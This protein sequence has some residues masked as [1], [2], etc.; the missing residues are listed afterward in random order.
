MSRANARRFGYVRDAE[1]AAFGL[2]LSA[3]YRQPTPGAGAQRRDGGVG[4]RSPVAEPRVGL[5]TKVGGVSFRNC[6]RII[7]CFLA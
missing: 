5:S 4:E 1:V 7:S 6:L 2:D 3:S